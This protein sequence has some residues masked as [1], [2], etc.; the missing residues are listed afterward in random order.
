MR[1]ITSQRPSPAMVVAFI[2]LLVALGGTS[3][4][5]QALPRNSVG[6]KQLKMNAVT[7]PKVKPGSLLR[8]DFRAG[9]IPAGPRGP[10]GPA[11]A[12]GAAGARGPAG[13]RGAIGERGPAGAP[14]AP[15]ATN[16][17]VRL[18]PDA[19][20]DSVATC[21][22]GERATGGGGFVTDPGAAYLF[23]SSP[24]VPSGTPVDW[25][26]EAELVAGGAAMVTAYVIC[27]AP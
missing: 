5:I 26:A 18:G 15:G 19:L 8:S 23:D 1:R 10:A 20:G 14:G 12:R 21:L 3:Y 9:Q 17:T 22:P 25:E 27:A 11:G 24:T 6:T 2:A 7:S 4:A 13:A 16:V